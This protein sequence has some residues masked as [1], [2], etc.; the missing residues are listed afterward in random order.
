MRSAQAWLLRLLVI[1]S[2]LG[3]VTVLL[4]IVFL[5]QLHDLDPQGWD[6]GVGQWLDIKVASA[7][8]N[9]TLSEEE[10]EKAKAH[11]LDAELVARASATESWADEQWG[12]G[13]RAVYIAL[14]GGE[15]GGCTN[16]GKCLAMAEYRK[17]AILNATTQGAALRK[18]VE[19]W[20]KHDI[21]ASNPIA[22][23]YIPEDY[24]IEGIIGSCGGGALGCSQFI[25]TTAALHLE[26]I[27]EPFDLWNPDT[28][29]QLMAAE[30]HRLGWN[31]N[32]SLATKIKVL[33][34]WNRHYGWVSGIAQTADQIRAYLGTRS[35]L[36]N[37]GRLGY[38]G[39]SGLQGIV[40]SVLKR[41]GLM[42]DI[43][44]LAASTLPTIEGELPIGEGP[45]ALD[46]LNEVAQDAQKYN[47]VTWAKSNQRIEIPPG[48]AWDFCTQM[49]GDSSQG[50]EG[51]GWGQYRFAAGIDAGGIC[52]NASMLRE[53]AQAE[54]R[55]KVVY[56]AP[57]SK[58]GW[59]RLHT[60][61]TCPGVS[62]KLQNTSDKTI[63]ILWSQDGDQLF[64]SVEENEEGE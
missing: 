23:Q 40:A 49:S 21:R 39:P 47:V 33:L 14:T 45:I 42:P 4:G 5:Y 64:V 22:A 44:V 18:F 20:K 12:T 2:A 54:G 32:A 37:I 29:M 6:Q 17:H 1:L 55:L 46:L 10:A 15:S 51:T 53:L 9:Y 27:G 62:F 35:G 34:G 31:K 43:E 61:I 41:L 57:H 38:E 59:A 24:N 16:C 25:P 36:A 11:N 60:V 56:W 30:L 19:I 48:Q 26:D 7:A 8:P 52:F 50:I 63:A 28:A 3:V 13:D 58:T